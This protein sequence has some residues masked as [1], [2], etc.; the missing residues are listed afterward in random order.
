MLEPTKTISLNIATAHTPY[1]LTKLQRKSWKNTIMTEQTIKPIF[2]FWFPIIWMIGQLSAETLLP[3][4]L[5]IKIHYE[6]GLHEWLQI[7]M[8]I[9]VFG[10][11]CKILLSMERTTNI[12]L[13]LWIAAAAFGSFYVAAEEVSWGQMIF[14]WQTPESW[15][16]LNYQGEMNLHNTSKWFNQKPRLLLEIGIIVGGLIIPLLYRFKMEWLP[17]KFIIIYPPAILSITAIIYTLAK[18]SHKI[19]KMFFD[20]RIFQRASEVEELYLYFFVLLYMVVLSQRILKQH[21]P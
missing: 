18:F 9:M 8:L 17:K 11:A 2:W 5:L 10:L 15:K 14:H 6:G 16:A 19:S 7:V 1:I 12:W 3:H 13:K 20:V 21:K 4:D